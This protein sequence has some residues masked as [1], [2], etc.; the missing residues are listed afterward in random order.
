M[1]KEPLPLRDP[2]N[3]PLPDPAEGE[4][5]PISAGAGQV[6][7]MDY[8]WNVYGNPPDDARRVAESAIEYDYKPPL[9]PR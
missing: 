8:E 9:R 2:R 5:Y 3:W 1:P 4:W 6:L 7:Q